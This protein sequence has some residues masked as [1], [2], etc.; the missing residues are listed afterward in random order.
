MAHQGHIA[1][2]VGRDVTLVNH[3]ALAA[4]GKT[5][6]PSLGIAIAQAQGACHQTTDR[7]RRAL[8]EQNAVG[9]DQEDLAI[10]GELAHDL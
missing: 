1:A 4:F 7:H 6:A 2:G 5:V 10:G 3:R 9:V 8:T